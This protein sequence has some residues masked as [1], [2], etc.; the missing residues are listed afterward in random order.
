M[1]IKNINGLNG[2]YLVMVG[3][4]LVPEKDEDG[5]VVQE[6]QLDK[7]GM[8]DLSRGLP[9]PILDDYWETTSRGIRRVCKNNKKFEHLHPL[10][11]HYINCEI[12]N[13]TELKAAY[14]LLYANNQK[15]SQ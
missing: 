4:I 1:L 13:K 8:Y 3:S 5:E 7:N 12:R 10:E 2:N 15:H 6:G 14:H 11:H 9:K